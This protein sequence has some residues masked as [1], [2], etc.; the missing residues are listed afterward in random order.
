MASSQRPSGQLQ[1]DDSR[2]VVVYPAYLNADYSFA[3][4]RKI[5]KA[6]AVAAPT[7][8]DLFAAARRLGVSVASRTRCTRGTFSTA[9]ASAC[10]CGTRA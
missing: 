9:A 5:P 1:V 2:W 7:V 6:A 3:K 4:G 10:S 8:G